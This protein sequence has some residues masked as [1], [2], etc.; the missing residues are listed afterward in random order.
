M[1]RLPFF[2]PRE[3][4]IAALYGDI[5]AASRAPEAF[6]HF[7]VVDD[8]EGRFERLVIVATL[9]LRRLRALGGEAEPLA[10]ALVDRLFED[11]DDGLRR[12]GVSDLAVGKRVKKLAQGFYG[13]AEAYTAALEAGEGALREVLSRNLMSGRIAPADIHAGLLAEIEAW[14]R[15]LDAADLRTLLAGAT[16]SGG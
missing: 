5:V 4:P 10:Q 2:T 8:F 7:G 14:R 13:R 11:L 12:A 1:I 6:R 3:S 15:R 9:V 16:L